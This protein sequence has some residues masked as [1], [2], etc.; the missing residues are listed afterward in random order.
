MNNPE[1]YH[2]IL[3]KKENGE[4][5]LNFA[6]FVIEQLQMTDGVGIQKQKYI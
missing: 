2:Q 6:K 3:Q 4:N 5:C 1:K